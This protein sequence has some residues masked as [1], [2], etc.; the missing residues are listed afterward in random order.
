M[1]VPKG[2]SNILTKTAPDKIT[3][4]VEQILD[5]LNK[6][7]KVVL[8][9]NSIDFCNPLGYILTKALPPGG[10]L[11][12]KLLKYGTTVSDFIKLQEGKLTPDRKDGETEEEYQFRIRFLQI[13]IEDIR[14]SL[15]GL[16]PDPELLD[17]IPGGEGLTK[18]INALN[19][20][21][22]AGSDIVGMKTDPAILKTKISLIS[23][24]TRKLTPFTN[25]I[26]IATLSIG[27]KAEELNNRLN[28]LIKPERFKEGLAS[29]IKLVKSIDKA[30]AQVQ[31]IILLINTILK[32]INTLIKIYAFILKI[33]KVVSIPVAVGPPVIASTV[34]ALTGQAARAAK[35]QQQIDDLQKLIGMISI[36]L[37]KSIL[38][39]INKIRIQII[40]LLTGLNVLYEN[41]LSCQY[42]NDPQTLQDIQNGINSLN[43]NLITLDNLFPTAKDVEAILPKTYNGYQIDIIKEEVV[44]E[45]ITLLRRRV[46]V[47]DQRGIIQ[48]EGKPTFANKDFILINEGQYYIDRQ[49][50]RS[51]SDRGND[52]PSDQYIIDVI[53]E[54]GLDS[55][56]TLIGTVTP[57]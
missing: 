35:M 45:G 46:V 54:I 26:N 44:D 31:K 5:I 10:R 27:S 53:T 18:T 48:Y 22:V 4:T 23:S 7:N 13:Q 20:A 42:T 32:L 2:L 9:L 28:G 6:I 50:Q 15:E 37:D 39:Q 47:A 25:P 21:L 41:I 43:N 40:R 14:Q 12:G 29:I 49:S 34:G 51:T 52:A 1:A 36:Y 19:L 38:L 33:L 57:D 24:F 30:I 55:T 16:L 3:V 17:I 8:E 11:E 56:N